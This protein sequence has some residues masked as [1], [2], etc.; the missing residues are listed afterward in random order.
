MK[1]RIRGDYCTLRHCMM[2]WNK[3]HIV[4]HFLNLVVLSF[5]CFY[6]VNFRSCDQPTFS[7]E[8]FLKAKQQTKVGGKLG[9]VSY[10]PKNIRGSIS[11]GLFK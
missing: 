4:G 3:M 6:F 9:S 1:P 5:V 2:I 8:W 10:P 11:F 7:H